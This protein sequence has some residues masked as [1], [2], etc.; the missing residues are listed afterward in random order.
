MSSLLLPPPSHGDNCVLYARDARNFYIKNLPALKG[1][2]PLG[3]GLTTLAG[4]QGVIDTPKGVVP[5]VGS[6]AV[7][8]NSLDPATGHV[9]VVYKVEGNLIYI[10]EAN[11]GSPTV[12]QNRSMVFND[13]QIYGYLY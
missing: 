3:F 6:V 5:R 4:K 11:Y 8:Y 13:R 12:K 10:T 7:M 1:A 2:K 9:A